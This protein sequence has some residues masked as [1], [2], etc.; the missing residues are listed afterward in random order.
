MHVIG[1]GQLAP[2]EAVLRAVR[3]SGADGAQ[4]LVSLV[5]HYDG[6]GLEPAS[7][8]HKMTQKVLVCPRTALS[9]LLQLFL[10]PAQTAVGGSLILSAKMCTLCYKYFSV[11]IIVWCLLFFGHS[12]FLS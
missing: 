9:L 3:G 11:V 1:F 5:G 2:F 6:D 12:F 10:C 7:L 8:S 4:S